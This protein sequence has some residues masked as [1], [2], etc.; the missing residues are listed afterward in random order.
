MIDDPSVVWHA[1]V[2]LILGGGG[3]GGVLY[4]CNEF[5]IPA[6]YTFLRKC[7]LCLLCLSKKLIGGRSS[8]EKIIPGVFTIPFSVLY[9]R[10]SILF[11]KISYNIMGKIVSNY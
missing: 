3:G 6:L 2:S 11:K 5:W 10:E 7:N 8:Y 9:S 1:C 4:F